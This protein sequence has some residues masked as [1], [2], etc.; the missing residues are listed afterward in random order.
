MNK[1]VLKL[2]VLIISIVGFVDSLGAWTGELRTPLDALYDKSFHYLLEPNYDSSWNVEAWGTGYT[3]CADK[4]YLKESHA[5]NSDESCSS[6]Q[7]CGITVDAECADR[8]GCECDDNRRTAPLAAL[9]FGKSTFRVE[10]AFPNGM[11]VVPGNPAVSIA[12]LT[13]GFSYSEKGVMFGLTFQKMFTNSRWRFKGRASMPFTIIDIT[14]NCC[15]IAENIGKNTVSQRCETLN[16]TSNNVERVYAYR[17]DLLSVLTG[18]DDQPL[19]QFSCPGESDVCGVNITEGP[20]GS[21][22][23]A[24]VTFIRRIDGTI[25]DQPYADNIDSTK[26]TGLNAD[27]SGGSENS[28]LVLENN[29]DYS[30]LQNDRS[31]QRELFL[32]PRF[33]LD[34]DETEGANLTQESREIRDYVTFALNGVDLDGQS[35]LDF[36]RKKCIYVCDSERLVGAGD[37]DTEF[38]F[39][40]FGDRGFGQLVTGVRFPTGKRLEDAGKILSQALGNNGHFK[41]QIG[42]DGGYKP[43][44][45][46]GL[47]LDAAYSQV[48]SRCEKRAVPFEGATV[49]AIMPTINTC[50]LDVDVSWGYFLGHVDLN[51]FHPHNC[52]LG[53]TVGYEIYA[54]QQDKVSLCQKTAVD[55]VTLEESPLDLCLLTC[56]SKRLSHKIRTEFFHSW[57]NCELYAGMSHVVAGRNIMRESQFHI[58]LGVDF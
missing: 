36:L 55:C 30:E 24:P 10:E 45:Y 52:N 8:C 48:F 9:V 40:Y 46:F 27:G 19:L 25:P 58:G 7:Q 31:A 50:G 18:E 20:K 17:S 42:L 14:C 6:Y 22:I 56:E 12:N 26:V 1:I 2:L 11:V 51:F 39:G 38:S 33:V 15:N 32:L 3:R 44:D 57:D 54:K 16:G 41:L 13:P 34:Q 23:K 5:C 37:F 21:N 49:R 4:F 29:V 35:A 47:Y 53:F 43:C 28:R